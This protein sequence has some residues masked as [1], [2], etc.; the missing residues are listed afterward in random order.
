MTNEHDGLGPKPIR[1]RLNKDILGEEYELVI[2]S[3]YDAAIKERDSLTDKVYHMSR[4][5]EEVEAERG[6]LKETIRHDLDKIEAQYHQELRALKEKLAI[7]ITALE[8]IIVEVGTSTLTNKIATKA[9]EKIRVEG[10]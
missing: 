9:L 2:S 6:E 7:A 8:E 5:L 10:K 3:A 4:K 1:L